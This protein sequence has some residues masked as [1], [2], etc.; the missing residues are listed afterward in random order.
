M[1]LL[2]SLILAVSV[3]VKGVPFAPMSYERLPEL[4]IP[5]EA[6]RLE[7]CNGE[8]TVF[9]GHTTGFVST[10]TAEYF[11]RGRWHTVQ[12]LYPHDAGFA[13]KLQSGEVM[14]GGGYEQAFGVGQTWGVEVYDPLQHS[15]TYRPI[16]DQKRTHA[17]AVEMPDGRVLVAGNWYAPDALEA[18]APGETFA[19]IKPLKEERGVPYILK[20][21]PENVLILGDMGLRGKPLEGGWVDQLQ[22][23]SFQEPLLEEWELRTG[24]L[25]F[26]SD[27]FAI[28]EY[29]YLL[30]V[31]KADGQMAL[32]RVDHGR[33]S[34]L[35]TA[36][37]LPLE[38]PWGGLKWELGL[39]VEPASK[40]AWMHGWDQGNRFYLLCIGYG[41]SPAAVEVFY[42]EPLDVI[43][44]KAAPLALPGGD[45]LMAGG[46]GEDSYDAL[47]SVLLFHTQTQKKALSWWWLLLGALMAVSGTGLYAGVRRPRQT[48][49]APAPEKGVPDLSTQ[50]INLMEEE[51]LFRKPDLR[52]TDI[53]TRLHT[54]TTYISACINSQLGTSFPRFVTRYRIRYAQEQ[55]KRF[56]DKK[57]SSIIDEAGFASE[58][59]FFRCF[60][61][62]TGCTPAEWKQQQTISRGN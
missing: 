40:T 19:I 38:G 30:P 60:K 14:L 4:N 32:L 53:A 31:Y 8:Y 55:M 62:E 7:L 18:A 15:F 49:E 54:N 6:H 25:A 28:G 27:L 29:D 46:F 3:N 47:G 52:L 2:L 41:E 34:L 24:N 26:P 44:H 39:R 50:I 59:N 37:P 9:G 23:E 20:T 11:R 58:N 1:S 35:E 16:L 48:E 56:P 36:Q 10:P 51:Q 57:L 17:S 22:G 5:R 13:L 43:P 45:Y 21:G 61:A 12:T 33:F 42:S